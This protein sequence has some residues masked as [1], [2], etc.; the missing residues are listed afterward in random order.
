MPQV[1]EVLFNESDALLV[2]NALFDGTPLN[3]SAQMCYNE[4]ENTYDKKV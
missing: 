2:F 3:K 1:K 4:G